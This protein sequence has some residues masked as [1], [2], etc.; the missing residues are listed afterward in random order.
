MQRRD[1]L[2]TLAAAAG[3]GLV[4]ETDFSKAAMA[5]EQFYNMPPKGNVHLLHF[6]DSHAQLVPTY[7]REP[8]VQL[9]G[10]FSAR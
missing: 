4:L 2:S 7:Y 3:G 10:G 8:S 5:A 6:T 9:G 1:F